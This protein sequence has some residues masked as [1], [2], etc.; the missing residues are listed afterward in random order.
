[1]RST[2]RG[3]VIATCVAAIVVFA[4]V[5]DRITAG[6]ARRYVAMQ[7]EALAGSREPVRVRAVMK[8][9]IE[10]SV[11]TAAL[12]A[13]VVLLAGL[14]AATVRGRRRLANDVAVRRTP[15]TTELSEG[16]RE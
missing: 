2:P 5:Q 8:P 3:I 16:H 14:G 1:M 15:G 13:G 10:H 6:G 11:R 4:L 9:A 12:A 7:R